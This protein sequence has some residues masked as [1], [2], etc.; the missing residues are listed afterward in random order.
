[1]IYKTDEIH[2]KLENLTEQYHLSSK[3]YKKKEKNEGNVHKNE[4]NF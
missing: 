1:M 4:N 3:I 2:N